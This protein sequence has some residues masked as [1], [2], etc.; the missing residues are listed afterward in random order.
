MRS[1]PGVGKKLILRDLR[2]RLARVPTRSDPNNPS[3]AEVTSDSEH[4]ILNHTPSR[5]IWIS[6]F[7]S[8]TKKAGASGHPSHENRGTQLADLAGKAIPTMHGEN[9]YQHASN[10][11]SGSPYHPSNWLKQRKVSKRSKIWAHVTVLSLSRLN[12]STL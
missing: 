11:L 6:I 10:Y 12:A 3:K 5:N 4:A 1:S 2:H 8:T 7:I 9:P